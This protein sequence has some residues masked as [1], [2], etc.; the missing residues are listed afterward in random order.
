[1]NA[2]RRQR[3][4]VN[5]IRTSFQAAARSLPAD[6]LHLAL[7]RANALLDDARRTALT[8]AIRR[9][10]DALQREFDRYADT[11]RSDG[12]PG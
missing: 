9:D 8:A 7:A 1:M 2:E 3:M 5:V 10:L 12:S 6:Q 11:E 4:N